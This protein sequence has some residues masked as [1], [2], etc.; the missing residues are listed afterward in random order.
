MPGARK[1]RKE[2]WKVRRG[3]RKEEG[4]YLAQGRIPVTLLQFHFTD[5]RREEAANGAR[6][7]GWLVG[8][9][10]PPPAGFWSLIRRPFIQ[11]MGGKGSP[12]D[13]Q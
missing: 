6:S 11:V 10:K 1:R 3:E 13:Q 4:G 9:L 8:E 5:N 7:R 12:E 2:S